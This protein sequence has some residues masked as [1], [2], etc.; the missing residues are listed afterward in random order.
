MFVLGVVFHPTFNF[1]IGIVLGDG[2]A[3]IVELFASAESDLYLEATAL[4]V[5]LE[6]HQ[7]IAL[8]GHES[9]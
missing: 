7:G 9:L 5:D 4:E 3:F 8:L 2:I 6:G 1:S